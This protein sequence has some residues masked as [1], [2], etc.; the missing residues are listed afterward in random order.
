MKKGLAI[1]IIASVHLGVTK[2]IVAVTMSG[3]VPP[4]Y[5]PNMSTLVTRTL[6]VVTKILYF[7]IITLAMYS[8]N[9]FPGHLIYIPIVLNS[10]LWAIVIFVAWRVLKGQKSRSSD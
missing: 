6:V 1:L 8:R 3:A 7:P 10:L 9:W 4:V 2:G 5:D